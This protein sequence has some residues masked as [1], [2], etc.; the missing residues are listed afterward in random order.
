MPGKRWMPGR[1]LMPVRRWMDTEQ[2]NFSAMF[3]HHLQTFP[4]PPDLATTSRPYHC[5]QT[6]LPPLDLVI[7]PRTCRLQGTRTLLDSK[8]QNPF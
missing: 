1:W 7:A 6:L 5:L 8:I 2:E 3:H 4:L